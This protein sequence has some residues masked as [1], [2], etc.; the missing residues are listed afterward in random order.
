MVVIVIVMK[1]DNVVFVEFMLECV[2]MVE[3]ERNYKW[4]NRVILFS[5]KYYGK[6]VVY[7]ELSG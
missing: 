7:V 1:V 3:G 2:F 4:I 5:D 6:E